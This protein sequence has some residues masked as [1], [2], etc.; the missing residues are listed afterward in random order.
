MQ[1]SLKMPARVWRETN[2]GLLEDDSLREL[3]RI[4][5]PTLIV[6]GDQD[7]ISPRREQE[8][9]AAS[10]PD[11]QLIVYRGAGHTF[12][13]EEPERVASDLLAFIEATI[14]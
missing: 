12:Y 8:D 7:S 6:W 13:L 4:A 14:G 3:D 2:R 5:A 11:S 9:V 10:I 1:Q